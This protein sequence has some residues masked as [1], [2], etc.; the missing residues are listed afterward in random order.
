MLVKKIIAVLFFIPLITWL[1]YR[2]G[3]EIVFDTH[4]KDHLKQ[5]AYAKTVE[6][7][8]KELN[9]AINYLEKNQLIKGYTSVM[10]QSPDENIE[11]WYMGLKMLY[12]IT[13]NTPEKKE[14]LAQLDLKRRLLYLKSYDDRAITPE[15]L[16][17]YPLNKLSLFSF[18][19]SFFLAISGIY[20]IKTQFY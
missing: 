2:I 12:F 13:K 16:S 14:N 11:N 9:L 5:A 1:G 17:I 10:Y 19:I 8:K 7:A 15:G 4:C 20:Y 18:V 6:D 3:S